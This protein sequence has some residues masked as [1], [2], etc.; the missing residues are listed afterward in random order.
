MEEPD[1]SE[2]QFSKL[3]NRGFV[4]WSWLGLLSAYIA[5]SALFVSELYVSWREGPQAVRFSSTLFS[6]FVAAQVFP[7]YALVFAWLVFYRYS[8]SVYTIA[9]EERLLE[10]EPSL[11]RGF[12]RSLQ[13]LMFAWL[14]ALLT[15]LVSSLAQVFLYR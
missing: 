9:V 5:T 13:Y 12:G 10:E 15:G 3:A 2:G 6:V 8:M 4:V 1:V 14:G 7:A 11:R